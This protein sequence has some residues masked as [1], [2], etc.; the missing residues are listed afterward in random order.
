MSF[1]E[2]KRREIKNYILRKID[3]DDKDVINKTADAFGISVTSVKRYIDAELSEGHIIKDADRSC[4]LALKSSR[5]KFAYDMSGISEREDGI[6][7]DDVLPLMH[8]NDSAGRIWRYV[9]PE[10]FNNAIEHSEADRVNVIYTNN[11]LYGSVTII[12]N[13]IGIFRKVMEA[14]KEYGYKDPI[15]EDAVTELYKGRFTSCPDRHTG[16]GIFF[17][18]RLLDR[19]AIISDGIILRHGYEGEPSFVR[20]HLLDYALKLTKKGTVVTMQLENNTRREASEVFEEYSNADEG[21]FRTRIPIFE[22]CLD[23][24]P[25]ARSQARRLCLRLNDFREAVLD[26]DKVEIMGQGF[27]DEIFRVYHN[28]HP[29]VKLTPV[30]MNANVHRLYLH[31]QNTRV[32]IPDY[33]E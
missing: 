19:F 20:S 28:N 5:K 26:F 1:T 27:A 13:G 22:A 17:S 4:A 21:F 24:D 14:M 31:A 16:E 29:E 9:L 18:M 25:V 33:S 23:R 11:C 15:L 10:I 30:G 8:I 3:E 12:D 7:Y 6:V 2:T 32:K